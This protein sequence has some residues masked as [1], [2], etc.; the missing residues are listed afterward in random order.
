V[1]G[2]LPFVSTP[3]IVIAPGLHGPGKQRADVKRWPRKGRRLLH[4]RRVP[5]RLN[6]VVLSRRQAQTL[7]YSETV[8]GFGELRITT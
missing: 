4:G 3:L 1:D 8:L 6:A 5:E 7:V 2:K